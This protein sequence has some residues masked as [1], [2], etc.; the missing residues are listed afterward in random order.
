MFRIKFKVLHTSTHRTFLL[1]VSRLVHRESHMLRGQPTASHG[2][3]LM[4]TL[5]PTHRGADGA[6]NYLSGRMGRAGNIFAIA[7]M[8]V[9]CFPP[10]P[11]SSW[12][13]SYS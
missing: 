5:P 13:E 12:E 6:T 9:A 8:S 7:V 4:P 1:P 11:I 10:A 2:G 3:L